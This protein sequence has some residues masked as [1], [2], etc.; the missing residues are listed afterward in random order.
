MDLF[1][2]IMSPLGKEHCMIL[3]YFGIFIFLM[4]LITVLF[5]VMRVFDN[6]NK[7]LFLLLLFQGLYLFFVYY[8]LRIQ[9]SMCVKSL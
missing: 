2:G 7:G 4:A 9:Y 5:S 3:Y 8:L 1:G 6:K